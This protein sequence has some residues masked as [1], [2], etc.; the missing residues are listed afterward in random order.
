MNVTCTVPLPVPFRLLA[1]TAW[2]VRR[3]RAQLL[4]DAEQPR[5]GFEVGFIVRFL[6]LSRVCPG[7]PAPHREPVPVVARPRG[8]PGGGCVGGL[9]WEVC[10]SVGVP[11][12]SRGSP[13]DFLPDQRVVK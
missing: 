4:A 9:G 10:L 1:C 2:R 11:C 6:C 12:V 3:E 5:A 8:W 13:G 7:L